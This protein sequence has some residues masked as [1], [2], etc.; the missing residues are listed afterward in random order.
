MHGVGVHAG[1]NFGFP[2]H[3][4]DMNLSRPTDEIPL[5]GSQHVQVWFDHIVGH[6]TS[7][8]FALHGSGKR[9]FRDTH[10][11]S[12]T[13]GMHLVTRIKT[14]AGHDAEHND[15]IL[16]GKIDGATNVEFDLLQGLQI[17]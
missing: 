12:I 11:R 6:R 9:I 8:K 7:C 4:L 13:A 2:D 17:R 1:L 3:D 10:Q 14:F 5:L 15:T 16:L